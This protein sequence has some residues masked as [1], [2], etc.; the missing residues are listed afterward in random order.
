MEGFVVIM[1]AEYKQAGKVTIWPE[2][3]MQ[4]AH[5]KSKQK[6]IFL[7]PGNLDQEGKTRESPDL[8]I[9]ACKADFS[10]CKYTESQHGGTFNGQHSTADDVC[11]KQNFSIKDHLL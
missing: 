9:V 6:L 2:A 11:K 8:N 3:I 4:N 1:L 10:V 7:V 5:G